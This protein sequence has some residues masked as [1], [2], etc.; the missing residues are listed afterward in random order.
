MKTL[1]EKD[2]LTFQDF[3]ITWHGTT[4]HVVILGGE[5]KTLLNLSRFELAWQRTYF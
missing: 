2:E 1:V 5:M 3:D 4:V